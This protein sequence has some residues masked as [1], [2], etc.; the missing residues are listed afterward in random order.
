M[1]PPI[2]SFGGTSRVGKRRTGF[3][4]GFQIVDGLLREL[5]LRR[6]FRRADVQHGLVEQTFV[7]LTRCDDGITIVLAEHTR[8]RVETDTSPLLFGTVTAEAMLNE[9]RTDAGFK[10]AE[11]FRLW[12]GAETGPE[13]E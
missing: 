12:L 6:H 2:V 7:R 13:S 10:E 9:K 11:R 4:P 1:F 8:A 3:D 5:L